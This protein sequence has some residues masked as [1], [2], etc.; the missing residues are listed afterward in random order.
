MLSKFVCVSRDRVEIKTLQRKSGSQRNVHRNSYV[1]HNSLYITKNETEE[2]KKTTFFWLKLLSSSSLPSVV[3]ER[4]YSRVF[5][6][7]ILRA[8]FAVVSSFL[9]LCLR[10]RDV[11]RNAETASLS[12][13]S[14]S[15]LLKRDG[16]IRSFICTENSK[17][18][19]KN[20][21][22]LRVFASCSFGSHRILAFRPYRAVLE[23][24]DRQ[25][26]Q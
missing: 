13:Y 24:S 25:Q 2:M 8:F 7:F 15:V 19:T 1:E 22:A 6:F 17:K 23:L 16:N 4:Y 26:N 18:I 5:P 12:F 11:W 20:V 10:M 14:K 9:L 21:L 3:C